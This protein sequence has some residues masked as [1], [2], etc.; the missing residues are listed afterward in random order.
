[1]E[2]Q[3][4]TAYDEVSYPNY[5][6]AQSHPDR[7]ATVARLLGMR[8][9]P[10]ERCRVL[11]IACGDG[12]N[13]IPLALDLVESEF[14][15]IDLAA[16]PVERGQRIIADLGL[17]NIVLQRLDLMALPET[18]GQFD[19]IIAHGFYSWVPPAVQ[20]R[21]MEICGKHLSPQGVAYISYN[22][23]PGCRLREITRDM[24]LFHIRDVNNTREAMGQA[25]ALVKWLAE[26][27]VKTTTYKAYLRDTLKSFE[28]KSDGAL[29]HDDLSEINSPVYFHQFATHAARYGLQF[30]SEADYFEAQY[31][32]F[33]AEVT[34]QLQ[35]MSEQDILVKEQYL[36]FLKCRSFRQTLL[37]HHTVALDRS[38]KP[39]LVKEF[40]IASEAKPAEAEPDVR[41]N[42]VE[43][44]NHPSEGKM[45]TNNPLAKAAMLYLSRVHPRYVSF[46]R[47]LAEARSLAGVED[48]QMSADEETEIFAS[49]LMQAYGAGVIELHSHMP[50]FTLEVTERPLASPL[51]RAQ[52]RDGEIVTTLAYKNIKLDDVLG[53]Q[54]LLL[55]DG[56][57]DHAALLLEMQRLVEAGFEKYSKK[58]GIVNEKEEILKILPAQLEE[59]LAELAQFGLLRA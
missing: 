51:A 34:Q 23:Y 5:I 17:K 19:Y 29:Y 37:C 21:M 7:L 46:D 10:V 16:I 1:M 43:E 24:M 49:A 27:Q 2:R 45:T 48:E 25:R 20:D 6:Y 9:A 56:T 35:Q 3:A 39:E 55:L 42:A 40:Y 53:K 26:A 50:E 11:E 30:L 59:R 41:S 54:L 8:P 14:V 36:D 52:A 4:Q 58:E 38:F 12:S 22:T 47:L 13:L 15:G 33:P 32:D 57:R 44:F 31:Q 18:L 28:Q